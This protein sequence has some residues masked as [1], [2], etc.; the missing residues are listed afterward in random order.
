MNGRIYDP[1]L[2]GF[3][4]ADTV[5]D[6][7]YSLQGYNRYSYVHNNPLT[8]KDKTGHWLGLLV[9]VAFLAKDTYE[10]ATGKQSG[11]EYTGNIVLTVGCAGADIFTGGGGAAVNIEVHAGA[12]A[13]KVGVKLTE[14]GIKE[15]ATHV[16]VEAAGHAADE[17]CGELWRRRWKREAC[18]RGQAKD[19]FGWWKS[20]P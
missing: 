2:G 15:A 8:Y 10:F 4:S 17:C 7:P 1:L 3:L 14:Q 19:G 18:R 6:G 11:A 20:E 5:V 9:D 13:L 16:V 12:A